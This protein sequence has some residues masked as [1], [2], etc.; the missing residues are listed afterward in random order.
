M[1]DGNQSSCY[2]QYTPLVTLVFYNYVKYDP[3][4]GEE[5]WNYL[6]YNKND[7]KCTFI[8]YTQKSSS[9]YLIIAV[10]SSQTIKDY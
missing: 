8:N 5:F 6:G 7:S 2:Q 10:P 3:F 4:K 9:L 1:G